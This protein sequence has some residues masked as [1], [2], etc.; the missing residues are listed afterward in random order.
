MCISHPNLQ[1]EFISMFHILLLDFQSG[2]DSLYNK[3]LSCPIVHLKNLKKILYNFEMI[4]ILSLK[5]LSPRLKKYT[6]L[7]NTIKLSFS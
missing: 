5:S 7:T 2:M 1:L 4:K 3:I 6:L